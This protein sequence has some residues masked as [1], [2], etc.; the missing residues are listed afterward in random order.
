[1]KPSRKSLRKQSRLVKSL[2]AFVPPNWRNKDIKSKRA[3]RILTNTSNV[4]GHKGIELFSHYSKLK[5]KPYFALNKIEN[6]K[7]REYI[8]RKMAQA[9]SEADDFKSR[10][11]EFHGKMF[12]NSESAVKALLASRTEKEYTR[13]LRFLDREYPNV[14]D[15]L[16]KDK[17]FIRKIGKL[18]RQWDKYPLH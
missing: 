16:F 2:D 11:R 14:F 15:K 12:K 10:P 18:Q 13:I 8:S 6:P 4:A 3:V 1:M 17:E 7:V 5:R 9:Q